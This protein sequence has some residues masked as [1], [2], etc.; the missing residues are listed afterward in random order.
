MFDIGLTLLV[1]KHGDD[2]DN[3]APCFDFEDNEQPL[4]Q[5]LLQMV[6]WQHLF[7]GKR[8]KAARRP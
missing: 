1:L 7:L 8:E 2:C 4:D 3:L 5:P 6:Q